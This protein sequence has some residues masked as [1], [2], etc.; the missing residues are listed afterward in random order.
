MKKL[1]IYI[2]LLLISASCAHELPL[3]GGDKDAVPPVAEKFDPPNMSTRFNSKKITIEFDEFVKLKDPSKQILVS[4]PG[5]S[6]ETTEKGKSIEITITSALRENTTYVVNFGESVADNNEGNVL[7]NLV[8]SF[9][10]GDI[11]D[12]LKTSFKVLDAYTLK[13]V[14]GAH[15]MLYE[16]DIDSLPLTSLPYYAGSSNA[17]GAAVIGFMKPGNF[18][19]FV[20]LEENKNYLFDKTN[21]GIGFL[22]QTVTSGDSIVTNIMFFKETVLNPKIQTVKMPVA[23]MVNFKFTGSVNKEQ[24]RFLSKNYPLDTSKLELIGPKKDSANYWFK[25]RVNDDTLQLTFTRIMGEIDT[26]KIT[27]RT[28]NTYK[29]NVV[30]GVSPLKIVNTPPADFDYYSKLEFEFT[31]PIDSMDTQSIVLKE[32]GTPVTALLKASDGTNRKFYFD[33]VFKQ[34]KNYSVYFPKKS[35]KSIL[36][37]NLDSTYFTF[38]TTNDKNYKQL[39]LKIKN[40]AYNS[41]GGILQLINDKDV[42]LTEKIVSWS[43]SSAVV[44]KNL[45]Q[46]IYRIRLIYDT[47]GNSQWDPG[48]YREKKQPEKVVFFPQNIDIKPNFDYEL[49]WDIKQR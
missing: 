1:S 16:E 42:I 44:F 21:E 11:I 31:T 47:N 25:P 41:G 7:R 49:E 24:I 12:S 8:Y 2:F 5:T 39:S 23:G 29:N 14:Q 32:E 6:F 33:Y 37:T 46:G 22:P 40:P 18:K 4:P 28:I 17:E 9:S 20:L 38:K 35:V 19:V 15:V 13:P 27:P 36:G 10:T 34:S 26:F 3:T 43:D 45:R 48:N 30:T